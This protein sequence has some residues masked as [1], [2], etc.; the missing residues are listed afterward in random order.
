MK[1][2][3]ILVFILLV[4]ISAGFTACH[5][6]IMDKWWPEP[7]PKFAE[8]GTSGSNFGVVRFNLG[9][10]PNPLLNEGP[11][12]ENLSIV[13]ESKIGRLRPISRNGW[14]FVGW[15][16]EKGKEWNVETRPVKPEDDADKDGYIT[17]TARWSKTTYK[18]EFDTGTPGIV[19]PDQLVGQ[20]GR[21]IPPVNPPQNGDEYFFRWETEDGTPWDFNTIVTKPI[22]LKAKWVD[23][24]NI[25]EVTFE[26][27]DG[28]R[29]DGS[30]MNNYIVYVLKNGPVQDPGPLVRE[31]YAFGGWYKNS[32][33]SGEQ[34]NF[35]GADADMVTGNMSLYARWVLKI[36]VVKFVTTPSG[37]AIPDEKV[38]HGN[39]IPPILEPQPRSGSGF[40]GWYTVNG[41]THPEGWNGKYFWNLDTDKV[42]DN[43]TLY[44]RFAQKPPETGS[45]NA[46]GGGSGA[47]FGYVRFDLDFEP[48]F[49]KGEGPVPQYVEVEWG[50]VIGRV[51]PIV[52]QGYGFEG[53]MDESNKA[54]PG[55]MWDVETRPVTKTDDVDGDGYIT[56]TARWNSNTRTVTF[57]TN[58]SPVS[59]APQTV[60]TGG[61]V[62]Q[63][64]MPPPPPPS[65]PLAPPDKGF[66]GWYTNSSFTG[67]PWNF[68][69]DTVTSNI[70]L[71]AKWDD[72]P[73]TL[74]F[75]PGD[76]ATRPDGVTELTHTQTVVQGHLF[77]DPGPLT[78]KGYSFGGWYD[79]AKDP[80][81]EGD[82]WD[83]GKD[84]APNDTTI[85][86]TAKWVPNV[87]IISFDT[88]P[89]STVVPDKEVAH[90]HVIPD[91]AVTLAPPKGYEFKGWY[92]DM[93]FNGDEWNFA[94]GKV[95]NTMKLY[96]KW[97]KISYTVDFVPYPA[98][99]FLTDD[100]P[101]ITIT[102]QSVKY[103]EA[104]PQPVLPLLG[105]GR[106]FSGWFREDGT[107]GNWGVQ[108]NFSSDVVTDNM[109]LY[110]KYVFQSRTVV[111]EV[112]GGNQMSRSHFTIMVGGQIQNPGNPVR[113]GYNFG[114]WF[115]SPTFTPGTQI[116]F[117]TYR[118]E[119]PDVIAGMDP[120]YLYAKWLI[121][122]NYVTFSIVDEDDEPSIY[123]VFPS[124]VDYGSRVSRP[125][126]GD[127]ILDPGYL[128]NGWYLVGPDDPEAWQ[129]KHLWDFENN[130]V[131]S[132]RDLHARIEKT[133]YIVK[134]HLGSNGSV[135]SI[136]EPEGLLHLK[137]DDK[138]IE[139][140]IP[141][142]PNGWS[143]Y[144]WYS[145]KNPATDPDLIN[146]GSKGDRDTY[147]NVQPW[148]FD[149]EVDDLVTVLGDVDGVPVRILNLYARWVPYVDDFVWV[150]RGS[151]VMGDPHVTG[152]PAAY[153]SYPARMVTVDGFYI[154]KTLVTQSEY[155]DLMTGKIPSPLPSNAT[156]DREQRPVERVSWYDAV[157]YCDTLTTGSGLNPAYSIIGITRAG[158]G[159]VAVPATTVAGS[160]D[161][162]TVTINSAFQQSNGF[163]NGYRLPTEAEWEYAARGG[164]GV[165]G[166]FV[167]SG[168]NNA[169]EVAWYNT[170]VGT[171]AI[172]STQP[173]KGK[174]P[175]TLGL[176]DMSG[177]VAE[178][179]WD[180]LAPYKPYNK[181]TDPK[182]DV[183]NPKGPTSEPSYI[184][185]FTDPNQ[186]IRRGGGWSNAIGM[187]RNVA[188]NSWSASSANWLIGFRVVRGPADDIW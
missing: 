87:Y 77:Q 56:L 171:Q 59:I 96:A 179:C 118:I 20:G 102:P 18:V 113:L 73:C 43:V 122:S 99:I 79:K 109:T 72:N 17:L 50:S 40:A 32:D 108:W 181:D 15:F 13:Y 145:S 60:P 133:N 167:Y 24:T 132:S 158:D 85:E 58:G 160:I 93:N 83:F 7:L 166:N 151:F 124:T 136:P 164:S 185:G 51:R 101:R 177:N 64:V 70:T 143:F 8:T 110:A 103:S 140:L 114:G 168:S 82:P 162:A 129:A 95:T 89:S 26:A 34:W 68:A 74:S 182:S 159:G 127:V 35:S 97:E 47:N 45:G 3:K 44:A 36:Y 137:L 55:N 111:F 117:N 19:V 30:E 37:T 14:G 63:P 9:F 27:R 29:P 69:T 172:K 156:Q 25:V 175:N 65:V 115:F 100:H 11:Q 148:D 163:P 107:N 98:S 67:K 116:N 154:S 54:W 170:T 41:N 126:L 16:D 104:A 184:S 155:R 139:P 135:P 106:V 105:D 141:P 176:F 53:W 131:T 49:S 92:E 1:N 174:N 120:L 183:L 178:W 75:V 125:D 161:N 134:F 119:T 157:F 94:T 62:V 46:G 112:N 2:N 188:R 138:V 10:V 12:P 142:N 169:D 152:S 180:W 80:G 91:P 71:Y 147:L 66:A 39:T 52:R 149:T 128:L 146:N 130:I 78:K 33:L 48:D 57:D 186:R 22:K 5:N 165:P 23:D 187:V 90:D 173:I 42:T 31:G 28:K 123:T 88:G 150:P 38:P 121:T 144:N 86:L 61:R 81:M 4:L 84:P 153:H 76:K 6:S 21:I